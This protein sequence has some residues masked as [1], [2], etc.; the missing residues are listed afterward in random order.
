MVLCVAGTHTCT[1]SPHSL[2][3]ILTVVVTINI[4]ENHQQ[5][6]GGH[7][8][9]ERSVG[10]LHSVVLYFSSALPSHRSVLLPLGELADYVGGKQQLRMKTNFPSMNLYSIMFMKRFPVQRHVLWAGFCADVG[11]VCWKEDAHAEHSEQSEEHGARRGRA[12]H[13]SAEGEL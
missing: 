9:V 8:P 7:Q 12:A 1:S 13:A 3:S 2:W 5:S 11:R 6:R 4:L 10:A